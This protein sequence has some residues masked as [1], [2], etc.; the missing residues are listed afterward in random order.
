MAWMCAERSKPDVL[1]PGRL[2]WC[3]LVP[4]WQGGTEAMYIPYILPEESSFST[5]SSRELC[6]P[7]AN[8]HHLTW[9][10]Y[11]HAVYMRCHYKNNCNYRFSNL[12]QTHPSEKLYI[13]V[14][15]FEEPCTSSTYFHHLTCVTYKH[16]IIWDVIIK[17]IAIIGFQT[18]SRHIPLRS[19]V[20]KYILPGSHVHPVHIFIISLPLH[21]SM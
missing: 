3:I 10:T 18:Y 12:S 5:A 7:R 1:H 17:I 20:S 13:Q 15:P 14:H 2:Q 19:Y 21:I 6:T 8:H 4:S 16:A 9:V 11:K